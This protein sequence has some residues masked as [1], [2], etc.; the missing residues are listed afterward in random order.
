M[1]AR[2][3]L[4]NRRGLSSLEYAILMIAM[5]AAL[6]A[7]QNALRRAVSGQWRQAADSFGDG[8]QYE[9]GVTTI[10]PH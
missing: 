5:V 7:A 6:F 3:R 2:L 10:T 4:N 8:R 1:P 9:P